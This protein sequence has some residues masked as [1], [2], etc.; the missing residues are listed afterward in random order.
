MDRGG[1]K[2]TKPIT[3][4]VRLERKKARGEKKKNRLRL[5]NSREPGGTTESGKKTHQARKK[6]CIQMLAG[7]KKKGGD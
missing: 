4:G 3:H 7:A 5:G 2:K 6:K 1:A